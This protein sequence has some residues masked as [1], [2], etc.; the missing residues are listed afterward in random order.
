MTMTEDAPASAD[1]TGP[2]LTSVLV[3]FIARTTYPAL[4]ESVSTP[5]GESFSTLLP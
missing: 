5:R 3:D 4:P 1:L 2:R